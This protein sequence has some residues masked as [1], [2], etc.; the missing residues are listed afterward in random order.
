MRP[1]LRTGRYA[2]DWEIRCGWLTR[3][4]TRRS[5]ELKDEYEAA[6]IAQEKATEISTHNFNRRRGFNSEIKQYKEQK[7][8]AERFRTLQEQKVSESELLK[9]TGFDSGLTSILFASCCA[10]KL[11][12]TA[13]VHHLLWK[14]Y[15]IQVSIDGAAED[16]E[17]KHECLKEF[18]QEQEAHEAE[19]R[20]ARKSVAS[21]QKAQSKQEKELKRREAALEE[22]VGRL[23]AM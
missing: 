20:A 5:L 7:S 23:S 15:H 4:S 22:K 3:I 18:Q 12:E 21:A 14:L 11:Q 10:P 19:L 6:R 2:E 9:M 17:A 8:E 16:I 1:L 13:L